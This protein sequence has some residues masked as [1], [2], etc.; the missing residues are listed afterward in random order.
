MKFEIKKRK[1]D[2]ALEC[3]IKGNSIEIIEALIS[4]MKSEKDI[5]KL[6]VTA[7]ASYIDWER[8]SK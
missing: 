5:A 7:T 2:G 4:V 1:K 3:T 8:E 6:I